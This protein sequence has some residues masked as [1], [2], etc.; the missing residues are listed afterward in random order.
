MAELTIADI[1]LKLRIVTWHVNVEN[2]GNFQ[3][4][5]FESGRPALG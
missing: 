5:Y 2:G 3:L 4:G 1:A